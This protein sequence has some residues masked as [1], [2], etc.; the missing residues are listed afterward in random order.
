MRKRHQGPRYCSWVHRRDAV[1][2]FY[3]HFFTD[4]F[5]FSSIPPPAHHSSSRAGQAAVLS[6]AAAA[7]A[8]HHGAVAGH[9]H[10][11]PA[12]L[13]TAAVFQAHPQVSRLTSLDEVVGSRCL[14]CLVITGSGRRCRC[15]CGRRRRRCSG[16]GLECAVRHLRQQSRRQRQPP[17][18]A[19]LVR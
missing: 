14:T 10:P 12:H 15:C 7:A 11:L 2:N 4:F 5:G 18:P 16:F 1:L 9:N 13:Q 6:A 8:A 3:G 17:I 19:V